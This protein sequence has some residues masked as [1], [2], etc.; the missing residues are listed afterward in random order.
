MEGVD[1]VTLEHEVRVCGDKDD[2]H[3]AARLPKQLCGSH[4]IKSGHF[5]VQKKNVNLLSGIAGSE[6]AFTAVEFLNCIV[7]AG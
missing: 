1:F 3:L 2:D 7:H 4:P 6:E 5:D